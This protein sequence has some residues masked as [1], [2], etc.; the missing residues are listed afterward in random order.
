MRNC[1]GPYNEAILSETSGPVR[2][3]LYI[4]LIVNLIL[5]LLCYRWR[6]VGE[7]FI[8]SEVMIR[9][10]DMLIPSSVNYQSSVNDFL[11]L[12]VGAMILLSTAEFKQAVVQL[13]L[14]IIQL[15]F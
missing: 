13:L 10:F 14:L 2:I 11:I 6:K 9:F 3:L 8:Y 12:N 15:F 1:L 5:C 4:L 7:L